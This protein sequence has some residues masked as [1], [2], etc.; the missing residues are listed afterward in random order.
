MNTFLMLLLVWIVAAVLGIGLIAVMRKAWLIRGWTRVRRLRFLLVWLL[1]MTAMILAREAEGQAYTNV[2]GPNFYQQFTNL[3]IT[4]TNGQAL[5]FYGSVNSQRM[6]VNPTRGISFGAR[7]HGT[8]NCTGDVAFALFSSID[9]TTNSQTTSA[10]AT[11]LVG[12]GNTLQKVNGTNIPPTSTAAGGNNW[13]D[14]VCGTI[15]NPHTNSIVVDNFWWTEA[16]Q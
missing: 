3:P 9:G 4:L 11:L 8:N 15:T 13:R 16:N 5:T 12:L 2:Y 6:V 1:G 7:V 14:Y 10:A